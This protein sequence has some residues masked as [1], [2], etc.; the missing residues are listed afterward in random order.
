MHLTSLTA[1]SKASATRSLL[2]LGEI[3]A[4]LTFH[5]P[6]A[7]LA[8]QQSYSA[9][10]YLLLTYDLEALRTILSGIRKG[11]DQDVL[12]LQATGSTFL[13]F[14]QEWQNYVY[15]NYQWIWLSEIDQYIWILILL[16]AVL[17]LPLIR[18]RKLRKLDEWDRSLDAE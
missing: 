13:E 10:H 17:A 6:R 11:Q 1:L 7:E 12:F 8:Y 9:V 18:R 3:D 16:L 4:V 5:R 15:K 2:P 14:E